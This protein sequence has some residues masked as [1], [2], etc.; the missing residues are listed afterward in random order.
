VFSVVS[1]NDERLEQM[2]WVLYGKLSTMMNSCD[3]YQLFM[4]S[5]N[6]EFNLP[7]TIYSLGSLNAMVATSVLACWPEAPMDWANFGICA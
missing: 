4:T 6:L 3:Y 1:H 7:K 2:P 5:N